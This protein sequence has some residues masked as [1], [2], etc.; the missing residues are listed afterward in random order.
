M[1]QEYVVFDWTD[2]EHDVKN[3]P[4]SYPKPVFIRGEVEFYEYLQVSKGKKI[5]VYKL[6]KCL[7]DWS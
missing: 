6:G 4:V 1:L 7:L 5:S 3:N 2:V